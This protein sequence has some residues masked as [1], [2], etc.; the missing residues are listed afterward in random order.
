MGNAKVPTAI[1]HSSILPV[2]ITRLT[3]QSDVAVFF[4][5]LHFSLVGLF[6]IYEAMVHHSRLIRTANKMKAS[7]DRQGEKIKE[8]ELRIAAAK[9]KAAEAE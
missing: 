4:Q 2:D 6:S 5:A 3:E 7:S 9:G 8:L 1:V